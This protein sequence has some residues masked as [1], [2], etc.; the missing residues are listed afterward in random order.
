MQAGFDDFHVVQPDRRIDRK[1]AR[2]G[3]LA[4]NLL[5]NL[6]FLRNVNDEVT[7]DSGRTT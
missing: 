4:N 6:A 1:G 3:P 5:V 2:F 7:F